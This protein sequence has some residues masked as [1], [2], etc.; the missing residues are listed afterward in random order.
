M[1][2]ERTR[3]RE[4]ERH[5]V[6]HVWSAVLHQCVVA[7]AAD[8]GHDRDR[9]D[10][11]WRDGEGRIARGAAQ[12]GGDGPGEPAAQTERGAD[13]GGEHDD[14]EHADGTEVATADRR[15]EAERDRQDRGEDGHGDEP[16][17]GVA[18]VEAIRHVQIQQVP[19]G[20]AEAEHGRGDRHA[21]GGTDDEL[22]GH[23]PV[24]G[25]R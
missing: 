18:Q 19:E 24:A 4:D 14:E 20:H 7:Y 3:G 13:V 10:A 2:E 23:D 15:G 9:D 1:D 21:P 6:D 22:G 17:D 8:A 5:V 12:Q 25:D 11:R 16:A